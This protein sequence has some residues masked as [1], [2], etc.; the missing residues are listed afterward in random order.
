[1]SLTFFV[2]IVFMLPF[3]STIDYSFASHC[4]ETNIDSLIEYVYE[5]QCAEQFLYTYEEN[6]GYE[7]DNYYEEWY[8]RICVYDVYD[9]VCQEVI[10]DS[11]W[12]KPLYS[13]GGTY[14]DAGCYDSAYRDS[15]GSVAAEEA[16]ISLDNEYYDEIEEE[17]YE[18]Y[19]EY[20]Y[21]DFD[22]FLQDIF[23]GN[24]IFRDGESY[25]IGE[26]DE[27]YLDK[28]GEE[29]SEAE[30]DE[31]GDY[32]D[33]QNKRLEETIEE[34]EELA[35][36][37]NNGLVP[38]SETF[39]VSGSPGV[40]D[41]SHQIARYRISEK[42]IETFDLWEIEYSET[43]RPTLTDDLVWDYLEEAEIG[44]TGTRNIDLSDSIKSV[45]NENSFESI[46]EKAYAADI[47]DGTA[48]AQYLIIK[49]AQGFDSE[50]NEPIQPGSFAIKIDQIVEED[51]S[52]LLTEIFDDTQWDEVQEEILDLPVEQAVQ[53]RTEAA[54]EN[55]NDEN[56]LDFD[57]D[58]RTAT[59]E[60]W[61]GTQAE[62]TIMQ[63]SIISEDVTSS[64]KIDFPTWCERIYTQQGTIGESCC[65]AHIA[66]GKWAYGVDLK[67][68]CPLLFKRPK[69][70]NFQGGKGYL[71]KDFEFI[72]RDIERITDKSPYFCDKDNDGYFNSLVVG[73]SSQSTS[74]PLG[75]QLARGDDCN[76]LISEINPGAIEQCNGI[77]DDCDG[78]EDNEDVCEEINYYCDSDGDRNYW[79]G[80]S[81]VQ[82]ISS[83]SGDSAVINANVVEEGSGTTTESRDS[84]GTCSEFNCV[85]T[86]CALEPGHDCDDSDPEK[87]LEIKGESKSICC[88]A[89]TDV[90]KVSFDKEGNPV[91]CELKCPSKV[92]SDENGRAFCAYLI[93]DNCSRIPGIS[94]DLEKL[95]G[96]LKPGEV[97]VHLSSCD[98]SFDETAYKIMSENEVKQNEYV[99]RELKILE[100]DI[101]VQVSMITEKVLEDFLKKIPKKVQNPSRKISEFIIKAFYIASIKASQRVA[102]SDAIEIRDSGDVNEYN[103]LVSSTYMLGDISEDEKIKKIYGIVQGGIRQNN[104][105][106]DEDLEPATLKDALQCGYGVC[107]HSAL[108][109]HDLFEVHG[110]KSAV[111]KSTRHVWNRVWTKDGR[112]FDLDPN[113]YYN[114]LE[115]EKRD[116]SDGSLYSLNDVEYGLFD[117]TSDAMDIAAERVDVVQEKIA[118]KI[119]KTTSGSGGIF[120]IFYFVSSFLSRITGKVISEDGIV[121]NEEFCGEFGICIE[122]GGNELILYDRNDLLEFLDYFEGDIL[123]IS[124]FKSDIISISKDR[125]IESLNYANVN[126]FGERRK[127]YLER[128]EEVLNLGEAYLILGGGVLKDE[129]IVIAIQSNLPILPEK[130]CELGEGIYIGG[131]NANKLFE[132]CQ[133][134][135]VEKCNALDDNFDGEIDE[136]CDK[137]GDLFVDKDLAC[138]G[139]FYSDSNNI[140]LSLDPISFVELESGWNFVAFPVENSFSVGDLR[141]S[142]CNV[143]PPVWVFENGNQI[144]TNEIVPGKAYQIYSRNKCSFNIES[145]GLVDSIEVELKEGWNTVPGTQGDLREAYPKSIDTIWAREGV[146]NV[147]AE[148]VKSTDGLWVK[149][150]S[151]KSLSCDRGDCDDSDSDRQKSCA[152]RTVRSDEK[153]ETDL[154]ISNPVVQT[155]YYYDDSRKWHGNFSVSFD[156]AAVGGPSGPFRVI[157]MREDERLRAL[158]FGDIMDDDGKI[159]EKLRW[160]VN[161]VDYKPYTPE[162]EKPE[163]EG[164]SIVLEDGTVI[165]A[166]KKKTKDRGAFRGFGVCE[167]SS[168]GENETHECD[169]EDMVRN[170]K[171]VNQEL[172]IDKFYILVD[173]NGDIDE[174][175]EGNN[176]IGMEFIEGTNKAKPLIL[177]SGDDSAGQ[178]NAYSFETPSSTEANSELRS[179]YSSAKAV[180]GD[181]DSYWFGKKNGYPKWIALDLG[182]TKFMN[183]I[184]ISFNNKDLPLTFDIEVS[185]DGGSWSK[186]VNDFE[187]KEGDGTKV[188][189]GS[190]Q[191]V[192]DFAEISGRYLRIV[193]KNGKD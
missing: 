135:L 37:S 100:T 47:I 59:E 74:I 92:Y 45:L 185:G 38:I 28:Y 51:D 130:L 4:V 161:G 178:S 89:G 160:I 108:L 49:Y 188:G 68:H 97:I 170:Y 183:G 93:E 106:G 18:D 189:K 82:P 20:S 94:Y 42:E 79:N 116:N 80:V 190:Y 66:G 152:I 163:S 159:Y 114:Y 111:V 124:L 84:G 36:Y 90:N 5:E 150:D 55:F 61:D 3:S 132:D 141:D 187:V 193:E 128:I 139:E 104:Y 7:W 164:K 145:Y 35:D 146:R 70:Q 142:N 65:K 138:E 175:N 113:V 29:L 77:D 173:A 151:S 21:D 41:Y 148:N 101:D 133:S 131:D 126:V 87:Q 99:I 180:D 62:T 16:G 31:F 30:V 112:V 162:E 172:I 69:S 95:K 67:N 34:I 109:L 105:G 186:V 127:V 27:D 26:D 165:K 8:E 53:E 119:L 120:N 96:K 17:N 78:V 12:I 81:S 179:K 22:D 177:D 48:R 122:G 102:V 71:N 140:T 129:E 14:W 64:R 174:T 125:V 23:E 149:W 176:L 181:Y 25:T 154:V 117:L 147:V 107:R 144:S 171:I 39:S 155:D 72:E 46:V 103:D 13:I 123:R 43:T 54:V 76:D 167:I 6:C 85:P 44:V 9:D 134:E 118:D 143:A 169:I 10:V 75:C 184:E 73:Y 136:G 137:D 52:S 168:L 57:W 86:N 32:F 153:I 191:F 83:V 157:L 50:T 88:S 110:I 2:T 40:T 115:I 11:Y 24:V 19:D 63:S 60:E 33:K 15:F 56:N 182:E 121:T 156:V 91:S 166:K 98:L 1:M 158:G 192:V 58:A